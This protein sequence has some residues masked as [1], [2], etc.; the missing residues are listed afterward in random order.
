M[1][2]ETLKQA[3]RQWAQKIGARKAAQKM[4]AAGLSYGLTHKLVHG[5]YDSSL[6]FDRANELIRLMKEDGFLKEEV[7][8]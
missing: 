4:L 7:A 3:V 6:S 5:V 2:N 8:S 1:N